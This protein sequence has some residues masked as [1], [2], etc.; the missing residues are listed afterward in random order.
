MKI[1]QPISG[2]LMLSY[3]WHLCLDIR[4][5]LVST[6][7]YPELRPVQFYEQLK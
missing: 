1:P 6:D 4:K 5:Y 3:K 7:D 2:G